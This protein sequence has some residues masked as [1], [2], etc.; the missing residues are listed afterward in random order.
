MRRLIRTLDEIQ[1]A[2]SPFVGG[3]AFNCARLKQSGIPVPD[4]VVLTVEAMGT[5]FEIP[6]LRSWLT[7]LPPE[8]LLAVRSSAPGEDSVE[9]SFAG[10]H[11][12]RL[13]VSSPDVPEA[14]RACWA[15]VASPAAL[16]YRRA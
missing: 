16:A 14:V 3:K 4:G 5:S 15:S 10:V 13:N 6:E 2:D 1:P 7:K 8:I 12:T 9:H 11:E